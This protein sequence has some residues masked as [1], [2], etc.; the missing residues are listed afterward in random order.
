MTISLRQRVS[1]YKAE[2][3]QF[4]LGEKAGTTVYE[5]YF[6]SGKEK[7]LHICRSSGVVIFLSL[8]FYRSLWAGPVLW[9]IG[10]YVY[11]S[12]QKEKGNKRR[13]RLE[14]EFKDCILSVAANLRAGYSV[15]NAFFECIS[16]MQSLYGEEGLM[17]R[18]LYRIRRGLYNN[19][20]LEKIFQEFGDRSGCADI[21]EFGEVLSIAKQSGGNLP[22]IIQSTANLI[23]EKISLKQEI[24]VMVSGR[25]LEQKIMNVIPFILVCYIEAGNKGFFDVLY[26]NP[27]G[28]VIM[29]GCL[30]VYLTA[31]SVAGR[32]CK[33]IA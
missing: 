30:V 6:F 31:Y 23:G 22:E 8:F 4:F 19:L 24:Q 21:R 20:P 15:E 12:S 3:K 25:M 1:D 7:L 2:K 28:W 11:L 16:D 26:H 27:M 33:A 29:T 32:I 5:A 17:L 18:E 10:V 13:Q 9:P 14:V